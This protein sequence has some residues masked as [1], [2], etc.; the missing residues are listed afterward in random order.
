MADQ[1]SYI[2]FHRYSIGQ[3]EKDAIISA[4]DSGWITKGPRV[5]Q[6]ES[7]F[8]AYTG[9]SHALA[10]NSCTAALHLALL[11]FEIGPGDE[12]IT[13][14]LTF[15]ATANMIVMAGATPILADID[16]HT[17]NLDLAS[18][19]AAITPRTRAILPVH[20]AGQPCELAPMLELAKS[21]KLLVIDDAAHAIGASYQ[22]QKI[23]AWC[24]ASAFS[25]YATKN[26]TTGEGGMLT[27]PHAEFIEKVRP[28]SLHGL[29]KDAWKRYSS[30]GFQHY[31]VE[32]PGYKYNMT[33]LQAALGIEQ[34]K[35]CDRLT[36]RRRQHVHRYREALQDLPLRFQTEIATAESAYHLMS[37]VLDTERLTISRDQLLHALHQAGIGCG[38]HFIP[39]HFHP[40]YQRHLKLPAEAL[41]QASKIGQQ[42]LSL[43]L[44][45]DLSE[46][47]IERVIETFSHLLRQHL[48]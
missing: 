18:I 35:K 24:D 28:L 44:Y 23:G 27:S 7:D 25:F 3:E 34:L 17:L 33:D 15:V 10:L 13:T 19:E 37:V 2:H 4:L 41:P 47:D 20:L 31:L 1:T 30:E 38:V 11:G 16:P 46:G 29:S 48:R 21:H 8:C 32:A 22:Q 40:F 12:V 36:A 39:L 43:P 5:A 42:L 45:P 9:A 14:P 26:I 6:F